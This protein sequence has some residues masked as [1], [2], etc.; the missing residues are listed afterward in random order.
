MAS[1]L[2]VMGPSSL[3][4]CFGDLQ[5]LPEPGEELFCHELAIRP[6]QAALIAITAQRLGARTS[7]FSPLAQDFPGRYLVQLLAAEGVAWEGPSSGTSAMH[8][9]FGLTCAT[10]IQVTQARPSP[11]SSP[12]AAAVV[13]LPM[14]WLD[15][16][17][18][19][20]RLCVFADGTG[21]PG[22]GCQRSVELILASPTTAEVA[23]TTA[24][25]DAA[26]QML[27]SIATTAVIDMGIN[28]ATSISDGTPDRVE[29]AP[30]S[31]HSP[32]IAHQLFCGAYLWAYGRGLDPRDCLRWAMLHASRGDVP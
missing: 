24:D 3:G 9:D 23:T 5:R 26:L 19:G 6:R 28:G 2:C 7:L 12:T 21:I 29:A 10:A 20:A 22:T 11:T 14:S 32:E 8:V 4:L 18:E 27:G 17:P 16:A 25:L 31:R 15:I 1:D 13:A 30:R